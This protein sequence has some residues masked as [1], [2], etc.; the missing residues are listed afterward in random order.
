M[1][2]KVRFGVIGSAG[3][4]GNYHCGV[5]TKGEGPYALTALCDIDEPRLKEQSEKLN[6]PGWAKV[7]DF[8]A[9]GQMDAV[10]VATP[11]PLHAEYAIAAAAA[12]KAVISEKPLG[13]TPGQALAMLK[14]FK[15]YKTIAGIHYQSRTQPA[16]WKIKD[17]IRA[18]ELGKILSIRLMGSY[19]KSD[20]YYSLG[21]WR[22]RWDLEGGATCINQAP[23]DID[24]MCY[25]A[26]ES[27]PAEMTAR[28][29]NVYHTTSQAE[30]YAVAFGT[31]PNGVEFTLQVGLAAH[32]DQARIEIFGTGG[33]LR[34]ENGKITRFARFE[35]DLVDFART[36]AGPNPYA[37]PKA[38][39]QPLPETD[40]QDPSLIHKR[41]AEAVL[42]KDRSKVLV[43][44]EQ[45]LWSQMLINGV[46]LSQALG[47]K[48]IMLPIK[49]AKYDKVREALIA[50]AKEINRIAAKS[51]TGLE[52]KW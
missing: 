48:K 33:T 24:L 10:I 34:F 45:G 18:G 2:G 50:N 7:E 28:W 4:I 19:Y 31:F 16:I 9:Q 51:Q 40:P 23:H 36:Y 20:Y 44:A 11:H 30:D 46:Y 47:S 14:A 32:G 15:K 17:M 35:Q 26:A 27:M 5:L 1:D 12:R 52:A 42:T 21:G 25:L 43:P 38:E 29:T 39:E 22:G 6:L 41:F 37:A 8:L 3:L 13:A 49:P